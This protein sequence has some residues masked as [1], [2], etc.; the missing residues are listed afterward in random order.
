[1]KSVPIEE[2]KYLTFLMWYDLVAGLVL[3]RYEIDLYFICFPRED[4]IRKGDNSFDFSGDRASSDIT[5]ISYNFFI[6][7]LKF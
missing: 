6:F 3:I 1:M 4:R 5:I 2:T 7:F